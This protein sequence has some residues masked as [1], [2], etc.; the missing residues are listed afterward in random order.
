MRDFWVKAV[1]DTNVLAFEPIYFNVHLKH[2]CGEYSMG[3]VMNFIDIHPKERLHHQSLLRG[4]YKLQLK[5]G[6]FYIRHWM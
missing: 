4:M 1:K 3:T 6:K 5:Q 2:N